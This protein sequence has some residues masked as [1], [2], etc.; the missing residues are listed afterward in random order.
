[1]TDTRYLIIGG[2]MTGDSAVKGIR[3]HDPAGSIVLVGDEPYEPY[4]RPPL[5]KGLWS[6]GDEA[7]LWRGTAEHGAD[8]RLGR[9]ITGVDLDAHTAADDQ[10]ETYRWEKLLF[11]TGGSPRR[12][13]GD[14]AHVVYFRTLDDYRLLR[15]RVG[16]GTTVTV[17]GGGF[18]GSEI[19]AALVG[20]GA[21]VTMLFPEPTL[22][23][24]LFPPDLG[25]FLND[26]YREKGVDVRAGETVAN[27]GDLDAEVVVAGLGIVPNVELAEAAGLP[28]DN[29]IVVDEYGRA[30]GRD[31]VFAAGDVANYPSPVLGTRFRVEHEDHANTHGRVVGA[32]MAGAGTVYD[33]I[34]FF[35][36]DLFD[37]GYEAVGEVD[38]R[39]EAREDWQ[40]PYRKGTITYLD[41][42]GRPRGFLLW[43]VW[44]KVDA[45]REILQAGEG[46]LV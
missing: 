46:A 24:R 33:H 18:I 8:L 21:K 42:D 32:N 10:G 19:A 5:S 3:E 25:E 6:G 38:S 35:Y 15:D 22:G 1:M 37:L 34:P 39:L 12:F 9:R 11:A 2:G 30:G 31:D 26:Y 40:E 36:S 7:K 44:D 4:K 20:V 43:N 27:V 13:G 23:F 16:Q 28:V 29:G 14:D 45:A 17:I 41:G